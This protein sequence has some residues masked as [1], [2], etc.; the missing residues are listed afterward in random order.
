MASSGFSAPLP[1]AFNG[2]NYNFW[3]AKMKAYLKAYDLWEITESGIE[4]PPLRANPTVAQIKQHSEDVAKKFKALSCIQSAISDSIFTRIMTCETAKEAWDKLKEEFHGSQRTRQMQ[5]LNLRREFEIL[6]MKETEVV[7]DYADRLMKVVNQIRLLGEDLPDKRIVEKV[8]I[9]LPEKFESKI[10]S[11]EDSR[12][13]GSISLAELVNAL[14]ATEQRRL[15]RQ[16]EQAEGALFAKEKHKTQAIFG[17]GKR[18]Q[19][20][21]KDAAKD[22][23][24]NVNYPPC[25]HCKKT[26]HSPKKCWFRPGVQC[27]S[28]KKFGH[29][30][31]VCRNQ[32]EKKDV[33]QAKVAEDQSEEHL[34]SAINFTA[35]SSLEKWLLDSGCTHHMT[36]N[37]D[38]FVE[39]NNGYKSRVK[40]GNGEYV[41]VKGIGKVSVQTPSGIKFISD[42]L[43]V[44]KIDQNLISVGQLIE[45]GYT[46]TFKDNSCTI[47]DQNNIELMTVEMKH[48]S[49][50]L[51]WKNMSSNAYSCTEDESKLWHKRF[52]HANYTSLKN[53]NEFELVENMPKVNDD[54]CVCDICQM[55]KQTRL[56][57]PKNQSRRALSKLQLVHSDVCGPMRTSTLNG[58]RYFVLFIDDLTRMCWVYFLKMKSEVPAV[59]QKFKSLVEN[60]SDCRIKAIRTDNGTEYTS[61]QFDKFCE[62]VGIKHQLTIPYSPQQNGVCERKNRTSMEMARCLMLEK[63]VPKVF[64]AEAVNTSIYL[65]NWL[66]TKALD[67]PTPYEAWYGA[68]PNISNLKVFGSVC[69]MHIP[70]AKRDKLS[71]KAETGILVGYCDN[72]KGYRIYNPKTSKVVS[73]RD[74]KVDESSSWNWDSNAVNKSEIQRLITKNEDAGNDENEDARNENEG[75]LDEAESEGETDSENE[76]IRT[77]SLQ[78]IYATC[79]AAI[80][81]PANYHDAAQSNEW[82]EAMK[83]ELKTIEKNETWLLVDRPRNKN[84]IGVKWVFRTK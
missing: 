9:S 56:P 11:L 21:R 7:K 57:F 23:G 67:R 45:K 83:D 70:D 64:W 66:P 33:Q 15:F 16:E 3:A 68:K 82:I 26:G 51:E 13:L 78:D 53:L 40:V 34:F 76:V 6:K 32:K 27:R 31:K 72:A 28:C 58:S 12:D 61:N 2:E 48:R 18:P 52:G 20:E 37:S 22:P 43:Y 44:P 81:E 39:M 65:L 46:L 25:P 50:P 77:R 24:R 29:M 60:E 73:S 55:G 14:Q 30:E 49:F 84:V 71:Q 59:F 4:P 54:T 63:N 79:N 8:L 10:S 36:A 74:V 62:E 1:A 75:I 80:L 35:S 19:N 17:G 42:V 5:V 38:I 69:Y 41:E 47:L